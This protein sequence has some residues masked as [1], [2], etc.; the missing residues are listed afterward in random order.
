[1]V[2]PAFGIVFAKGINVFS[3]ENNANRRFQADWTALWLVTSSFASLA[4]SHFVGRLFIIAIIAGFAISVQNKLFAEAAAH[5]TAQLRTRCFKAVLRQDSKS[6]FKCLILPSHGSYRRIVSYFDQDENSVSTNLR[7]YCSQNTQ[8]LQQTG[9][10]VSRLSQNP[11]K[12]EGLAG[13]TLGVFVQTAATVVAGAVL[14]LVFVW[15]IGLIGIGEH[16]TF[17]VAK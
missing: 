8:I 10:L 17:H 11:Q 14:G 12:F 1:M 7:T 2:Y 4:V 13:V 15:Q 9:S 3:L 16:L 5:L 6:C